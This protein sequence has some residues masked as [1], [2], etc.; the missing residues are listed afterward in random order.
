M[1]PRHALA[2]AAFT[3][4]ASGLVHQLQ[5]QAPARATPS[6]ERMTLGQKLFEGK[7]L[8]FSC[9]GKNG[10]GLIS[11]STR[12]VGRALTHTKATIA[13]LSALIK[14]GLDS[15]HTTTGVPMPARGGSRLTDSEVVAVATYVLDMIKRDKP[16]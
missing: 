10:E 1:N 4:L 12:L 13:D 14:S 9:H 2:I 8:C 6:P 11:P 5:A 16:H 7:A 15:A 3:M